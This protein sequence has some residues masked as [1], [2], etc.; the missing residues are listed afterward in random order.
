[1]VATLSGLGDVDAIVISVARLHGT[2]AIPLAATLVAVAALALAEEFP[3]PAAL[4]P[5]TAAGRVITEA[6]LGEVF[7]TAE[8]GRRTVRSTDDTDLRELFITRL[9]EGHL[10]D[11]Q[12]LAEFM[13]PPPRPSRPCVL[14][15]ARASAPAAPPARAAA[16]PR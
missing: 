12:L 8:S 10:G 14:P 13:A 3:D 7:R 5:H 1:M 6:G 16:A 2:G 9:Y 11:G 4:F 15:A